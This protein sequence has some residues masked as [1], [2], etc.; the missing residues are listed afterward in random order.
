MKGSFLKGSGH[1]P[2]SQP[3]P[4][5]HSPDGSN[6]END[7]IGPDRSPDN[8]GDVGSHFPSDPGRQAAKRIRMLSNGG[9]GFI[10]LLNVDWAYCKVEW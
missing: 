4:V 3:D 2:G 9:L 1:S 8:T 6:S 5:G 10:V 7:D